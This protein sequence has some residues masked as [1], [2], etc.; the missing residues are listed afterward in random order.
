[1]STV[2]EFLAK[3]DWPSRE[4]WI[5]KAESLFQQQ[6]LLPEEEM[7]AVVFLTHQEGRG[8]LEGGFIFYQPRDL[9]EWPLP[10]ETIVGVG[11]TDFYTATGEYELIFSLDEKEG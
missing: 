8:D 6:L 3:E 5:E 11:L 2:E 7:L 4:Q 1:M 9:D 10:E